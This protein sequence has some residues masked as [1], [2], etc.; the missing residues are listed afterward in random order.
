[1]ADFILIGKLDHSTEVSG[2][3]LYRG[4]MFAPPGVYQW[5]H[6]PMCLLL[7]LI[8]LLWHHYGYQVIIVEFPTIIIRGM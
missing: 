3:L 4:L 1:M 7:L 6:V 5:F 2:L 8:G